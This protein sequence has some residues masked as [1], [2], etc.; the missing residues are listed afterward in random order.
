M[1]KVRLLITGLHHALRTLLCVVIIT[2]AA[3]AFP[4]VFIGGFVVRGE[5]QFGG[6]IQRAVV[7]P[8]DRQGVLGLT[9]PPVFICHNCHATLDLEHIQNA[10]QP[11]SGGI[12]V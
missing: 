7:V 10:R 4:R 3:L 2:F 6:H 8:F 9:G 5:H 1:G 11:A 12:I